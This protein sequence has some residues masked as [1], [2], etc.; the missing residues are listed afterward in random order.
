[1][2]SVFRRTVN[3]VARAVEW[4]KPGAF[5]YD[6]TV[7]GLPHLLRSCNDNQPM[8]KLRLQLLFYTFKINKLVRSAVFPDA[9]S[10]DHLDFLGP[11]K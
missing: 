3:L 8:R 9:S 4:S 11:G 10:P 6:R 2:C 5:E 1:M 7:V